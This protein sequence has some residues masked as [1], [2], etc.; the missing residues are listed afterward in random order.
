MA[1]I[2]KQP[3][4]EAANVPDPM[5]DALPYGDVPGMMADRVSDLYAAQERASRTE[6]TERLIR[7]AESLV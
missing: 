2:V 7:E 5:R 3:P 6:R 4:V 1:S